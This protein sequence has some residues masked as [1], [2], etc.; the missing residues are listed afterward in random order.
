MSVS[1]PACLQAG[2]ETLGEGCDMKEVFE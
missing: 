2:Q 1:S